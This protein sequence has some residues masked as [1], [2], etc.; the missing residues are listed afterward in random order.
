MHPFKRNIYFLIVLP[1]ALVLFLTGSY[2]FK[3]IDVK[4][5]YWLSEGITEPVKIIKDKQG[6]ITINA[7]S[8]YDAFFALGFSH[9]RDR[10]WQLEL[11]RRLAQGRLS[12]VLG[13]E[14]LQRDVW[15][16]TVGLNKAA[17]LALHN[18]S[19]EARAVLEAYANG[20]NA[21]IKTDIAFP[22]EFQL[23]DI[24]MSEWQP[25]DSLVIMKL[26][27]LNLSGTMWSEV[28]NMTATETL[29]PKLAQ[30]I[31]ENYP[32]DAPVV[33][34]NQ[35]ILNQA[36]G[37]IQ[38]KAALEE[39]GVGGKYLGSNAWVV[40]DRF[41]EGTGPILANDPHLNLQ[42]PA[43]FYFTHLKGSK[44]DVQGMTLVGLPVVVFGHNDDI[45][46]GVTNMMADT[47][48]LF[49]EQVN[50]ADAKMYKENG[51][52]KA[53]DVR[54]EKIYVK[55][56]FPASLNPEFKPV[57]IDVRSTV[58]GPII[59]D[60]TNF[61][62]NVISLRWTALDANDTSFDGFLKLNYA[63]NWEQFRSSL[64]M[65]G[66]PSLNFL[67]AD[68][69]NNIGY[70]AVGKIPQRQNG[71]GQFPLPGWNSTN[72]WQG[73]IPFRE[74]PMSFNPEKGYIVSANNKIVGSEYPYFISHD[75]APPYRAQ[76]IEALIAS[77]SSPL[78]IEDMIDF[79]GDTL[80]LS[81]QKLV[82]LLTQY[83]G[84][85]VVHKQAVSIL[86]SWD[87]DMGADSVGAAI[88]FSWF[89]HLKQKVLAPQLEASWHR[90]SQANVFDH[91]INNTS[92]DQLASM[93]SS[94]T[95]NWCAASQ[96]SRCQQELSSSLSDAIDE[97]SLLLGSDMEQWQWGKVHKVVYQHVPFSNM[98]MLDSIFERRV[99]N[100]GS[101]NTVNV[102]S[103]DFVETEGYIQS[104][105]AS[106]RQITQINESEI[107]HL[108]MNSTGQSGIVFSPAYD[109]VVEPFLNLEF[110]RSSR[111]STEVS[112]TIINLKK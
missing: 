17:E 28:V 29:E 12:E 24:T 69:N 61:V 71:E 50:G 103:A 51:E 31:I 15:M 60:A 89:R 16:R 88:Y 68:K 96:S 76:R 91:F 56:A 53:F 70:Q 93:I 99:G 66:S 3:N 90:T 52:W 26:L 84:D 74:L 78:T 42:I 23:L 100:G 80:D 10:L 14:A 107:K 1:T 109:D 7:K 83:E 8:D 98:N 94:K 57:E 46:W 21:Y 44:L 106:F 105:G 92:A 104:S 55:Q 36:D 22:P 48:D 59:S 25:Q 65:V 11:Q 4:E 64:A 73:Y 49:L 81:A 37:L 33:V 39:I 9:A 101:P 87:L 13:A 112:E 75:W 45:T 77:K 35:E 111:D 72:Q 34:S 5:A 82:Q 85:S 19:S 63:K 67:Y 62:D 97:L 2:I 6:Y 108:H 18:L 40:A 58:R 79:Q 54:R 32:N 20:I 102:A 27:S 86:R 95:D 43:P 47:Q 38:T 41:T 110:H 30:A